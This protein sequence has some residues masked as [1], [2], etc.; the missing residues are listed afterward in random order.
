[1][2][3][4]S[5]VIFAFFDVSL[6][7]SQEEN[8]S[9]SF[10]VFVLVIPL[11]ETFFFQY[12]PYFFIVKHSKIESKKVVYLIFCSIIFSFFHY[13]HIFFAIL[14]AFMG[15]FYAI[16]L[17]KIATKN[18]EFLAII[19][20]FLMHLVFNFITSVAKFLEI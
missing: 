19:H 15:Y 6:R 13:Y 9:H 17:F 5:Y 2:T 11:F 1:M 10:V 18:G 12:V 20:V 8:I 4:I 3:L 16:R 7:R 14:T